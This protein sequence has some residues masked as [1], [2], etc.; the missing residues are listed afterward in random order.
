MVWTFGDT[1][2]EY[3]WYLWGKGEMILLVAL[4]LENTTALAFMAADR[5]SIG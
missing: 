3:S 5:L 4:S 1:G 2:N